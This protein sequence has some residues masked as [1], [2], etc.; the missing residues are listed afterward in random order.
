[1][2]LSTPAGR[3]LARAMQDYGG[4]ATDVSYSTMNVFVEP[5]P[6]A[7]AF[8]DQLINA[9]AW[10]AADLKKIRQHLRIVTN[11]TPKTPNGGTLDAARRAPLLP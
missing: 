7:K 6:G 2:G 11:N 10:D 4:Y 1:M 8:A 5:L 3:M 9:P